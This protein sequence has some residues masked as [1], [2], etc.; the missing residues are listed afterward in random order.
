MLIL[1]ELVKLYSVE[2]LAELLDVEEQTIRKWIKEGKS[3]ALKLAGTT[4]KVS[5]IELERFVLQTFYPSS[6]GGK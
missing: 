1:N 4:L 3:K 6:K 2:I 5:E